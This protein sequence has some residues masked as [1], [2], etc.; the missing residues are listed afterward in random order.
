ML[1]LHDMSGG[2]SAVEGKAAGENESRFIGHTTLLVQM[3]SDA[4]SLRR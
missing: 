2:H 4:A 3:S 1:G